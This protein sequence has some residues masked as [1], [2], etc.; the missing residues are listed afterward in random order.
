M[1]QLL[2]EVFTQGWEALE[3][4]LRRTRTQ[5]AAEPDE[6]EAQPEAQNP[7]ID[8][9]FEDPREQMDFNAFLNSVQSQTVRGIDMEEIGDPTPVSSTQRRLTPD[10][11]ATEE[12]ESLLRTPSGQII[13]PQQLHGGGR[14]CVCQG[15]ADREHYY[16]CAE[17]GLGMCRLH[18][19]AVEG[20]AYCPEHARQ[21]LYNLETWNLNEGRTPHDG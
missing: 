3:A 13:N 18:V 16:H 5:P 17:C 6:P 2:I 21:A 14:C 15:Y 12:R 19:C 20:V 1:I 8:I 10:G 7:R 11:L 9:S 4:Q